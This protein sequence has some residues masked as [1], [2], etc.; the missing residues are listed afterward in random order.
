MEDGL[1]VQ[2]MEE[3]AAHP[4]KAPAAYLRSILDRCRAEGILT[5]EAWQ[6]RHR[7]QGSSKRVD[8]DTPSG[9]DF[10]ADAL[11]RPRRHKRKNE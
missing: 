5:L 8:R 4:V 7:P 1:L 10:L 3:A 2:A 6:A 11:T 9:N